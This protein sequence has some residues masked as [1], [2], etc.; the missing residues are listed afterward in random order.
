MKKA[1]P[2]LPCIG[3]AFRELILIYKWPYLQLFFQ[4][5]SHTQK[6][7]KGICRGEPPVHPY[8]EYHP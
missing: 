6:V 4:F 7:R 3:Q 8:V 1:A 2:S 5:Q